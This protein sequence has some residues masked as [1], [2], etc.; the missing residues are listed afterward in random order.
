MTGVQTCALP[1]YD[2]K[3]NRESG[4]GR[5]DIILCA[6]KQELPH[7]ILEFKYTKE[8]TEDLGELAL[9]AIGQIKHKKYDAE[10]T[11]TVYFI[12]LAHFGKNVQVRW[13]KKEIRSCKK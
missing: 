13:E 7:M 8:E 4:A 3:S 6:K 2:V 9:D 10:M 11:G 12:G 1:I 5:S